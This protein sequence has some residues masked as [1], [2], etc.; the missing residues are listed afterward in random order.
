MANP[1]LEEAQTKILE[2]II[3]VADAPFGH[4]METLRYAEAYAWLVAPRESHGGGTT[5]PNS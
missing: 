2:A 1:K 5:A 3:Q 4:G